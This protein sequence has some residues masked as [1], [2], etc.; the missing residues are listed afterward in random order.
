MMSEQVRLVQQPAMQVGAVDAAQVA[1]LEAA[2]HPLNA[3]MQPGDERARHDDVAGRGTAKGAAVLSQRKLGR[4]HVG[5]EGYQTRG[6]GQS[7]LGIHAGIVARLPA[8][9]RRWPVIGERACLRAGDS[10]VSRYRGPDHRRPPISKHV[11]H[12]WLEPNGIYSG[13]SQSSAQSISAD[14]VEASL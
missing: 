1:K 11:Y 5:L 6:S 12:Q 10:L 14:E 4:L 8:S 13:M 3:R 2:I 7:R 9:G